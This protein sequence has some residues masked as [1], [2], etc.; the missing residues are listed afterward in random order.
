MFSAQFPS[1]FEKQQAVQCF[2]LAPLPDADP[3][4]CLSGALLEYEIMN[5]EDFLHP[6]LSSY[7]KSPQWIKTSVGRA[8]T[9]VPVTW[10]RGH[11][12]RRFLDEASI[13]GSDALRRMQRIKLARAL[14]HALAT[15]PAYRHWQ[16]LARDLEDPIA[17][18]RQLPTISKHDVKQ[19]VQCFLAEGVDPALRMKMFTGGSTSLPMTLY[20]HKGITRA[21]EYAFIE[22]F[23]Q[24]AGMREGDTVLAL[25]GNAVRGRHPDGALWAYEPIKKQL[26]L[27]TDHLSPKYMPEYVQAMRRWR[28]RFIQAFASAVYPLALWF[29]QNP[30]D[31]VTQSIQSIML[32]SENVL[33]HQVALLRSVFPGAVLKHYGHS[34]RL[35]MA[36][37]MPDDDRYFFWPQYG[38]FELVDAAGRVIERPGEL[39]EIVGTGFDNDVMPLVRY[40]TGDMAILS[41]NP[42]PLLPGFPAVERIEGRLQEFIVCQDKRLISL[43]AVTTAKQHPLLEWAQAIQFEQR[44]PGYLV[45]HVVI[46]YRLSP[47]QLQKIASSVQDRIGVGCSVSVEQVS[48]ISRTARGK[49]LMLIQHLDTRAYF[50]GGNTA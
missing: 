27:S 9:M 49:A 7:M 36:A 30:D 42:H 29:K 22:A 32:F 14:G 35:L 25:R 10:R 16:A 18:L 3:L 23:H 20:L 48:E 41:S 40:R 44:T 43:N 24:R 38:F 28:P 31:E 17:V 6:L 4:L 45:M 15:V 50:G 46:P 33:D 34:E 19:K 21:K 13:V 5:I 37:S 47:Q 2:R 12:Y 11:H 8:Y 39:G 1:A 26:M